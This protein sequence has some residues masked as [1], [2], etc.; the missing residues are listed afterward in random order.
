MAGGNHPRREQ[1]RAE[2]E[3]TREAYHA[4]A[5]TITPEDWDKPS[6]NPAWSVGELL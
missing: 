3:S 5:E 6:E 4:F 1:L 2:L